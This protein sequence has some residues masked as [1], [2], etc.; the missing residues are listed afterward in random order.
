[1]PGTVLGNTAVT[2]TGKDPAVII[3][4]ILMRGGINKLN[5][6]AEL[7]SSLETR[8]TGAGEGSPGVLS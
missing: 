5:K 8:K 6:C 4:Y 3:I 2:T 7:S 1:M